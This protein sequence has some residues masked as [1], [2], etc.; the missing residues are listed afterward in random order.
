MVLI[1]LLFGDQILLLTT[2][3]EKLLCHCHPAC[4]TGENSW[5]ARGGAEGGAFCSVTSLVF[6]HRTSPWDHT[7]PHGSLH[8]PL[9]PSCETLGRLRTLFHLSL[10]SSSLISLISPPPAPLHSSR[11]TDTY[12]GCLAAA[13]LLS[14]LVPQPHSQCPET[15]QPVTHQQAPWR[16]PASCPDA[17]CVLISPGR[18]ACIQPLPTAPNTHRPFCSHRPGAAPSSATAQ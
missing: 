12:T 1:I 4:I 15:S 7:L 5:G 2:A 6:G 16:G 3:S 8:I 11:R 17:L 13:Q 18:S 9:L 14:R 10:F